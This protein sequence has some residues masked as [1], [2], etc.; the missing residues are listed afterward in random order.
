MFRLEDSSF[1]AALKILKQKGTYKR[2]YGLFS[3]CPGGV[4]SFP[5]V[6]EKTTKALKT[7]PRS[8]SW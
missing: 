5:L 8:N 6:S 1:K 7:L 4:V 3:L 2:L